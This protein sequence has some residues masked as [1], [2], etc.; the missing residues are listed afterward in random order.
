M[1]VYQLSMKYLAYGGLV[2][3][4]ILHDPLVLENQLRYSFRS[5]L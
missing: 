5:S 2:G 1:I 3:T 4:K